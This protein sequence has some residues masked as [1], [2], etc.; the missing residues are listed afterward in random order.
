MGRPGFARPTK[1]GLGS[2]RADGPV[3]LKKQENCAAEIA[4]M[5]KG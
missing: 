3:G 1:I 2:H 4:S 5:V